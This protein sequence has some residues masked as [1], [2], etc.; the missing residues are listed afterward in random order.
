MNFF[1]VIFEPNEINILK[2]NNLTIINNQRYYIFNES[3]SVPRFGV[4]YYY[5]VKDFQYIGSS[6]KELL[7][8]FGNWFLT[9]FKDNFDILNIE[10]RFKKRIF[11]ITQETNYIGP[12]QNDLFINNNLGSNSWLQIID[13]FELLNVNEKGLLAIRFPFHRE[14]SVISN[15]IYRKEVALFYN[16]LLGLGYGDKSVKK[17][18]L[19]MTELNRI[20]KT[21][22]AK[23]T[24]NHSPI[25]NDYILISDNKTELLNVISLIKN[26]QHFSFDL[27][28]TIHNIIDFKSEI[29][30]KNENFTM[31]E[32]V[33]FLPKKIIEQVYF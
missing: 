15:L 19:N 33:N 5:K 29:Y 31:Y 24:K 23:E 8:Q 32:L 10:N 4:P 18:F 20:F 2:E 28:S 25:T 22:K 30:Y 6:W 9:N 1:D 17:H 13:L 14:N 16:Y 27:S 3:N 26:S 21:I 7:I 11:S 12:L